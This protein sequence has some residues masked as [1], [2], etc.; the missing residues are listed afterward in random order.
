MRYVF[1]PP[2]ITSL[3]IGLFMVGGWMTLALLAARHEFK[4][5]HPVRGTI[6]VVLA[7]VPLSNLGWL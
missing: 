1:L 4:H 3:V 7:F 6:A 2:D 5:N